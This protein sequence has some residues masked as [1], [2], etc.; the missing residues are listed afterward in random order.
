[1]KTFNK[2]LFALICLAMLGTTAWGQ[3]LTDD[4]SYT[5]GTLLTA[6][7]WV[8]HSGA[9][10]NSHFVVYPGLTYTGHA[11]SGIGGADTL[12]T[13]GE[14]VNSYYT[15][16]GT[17]ISTGTAYYSFIVKLDTAQTTGDYFAHVI[18][19]TRTTTTTFSARVWAKRDASDATKFAFG[20]SKSSTAANVAYTATTA[21]TLGTTYFV[22]VKYIFM[23]GLANDSVKLFINPVPGGTEPTPTLSN[24]ALDIATTDMT[25]ID[26][27]AIRQGTAGSMPRGKIDAFRLGTTWAS[28]TTQKNALSDIIGNVSFVYPTNIDYASNTG[29]NVTSSNP[30]V[31]GLVIRDGG[32][33]SPDG[34]AFSTTL[35]AITLSVTN[36]SVLEKVALYS[37]TTELSE[38]T[39]GSTITFSG[40]SRAAADNGTDTLNLRATYKTSVTDNTQF[41]FTVTSA[42][43]DP[44]GSTFAAGNAGGATSSTSGNDDRI[45]VTATKY[46]FSTQPPATAVVNT[47]FAAGVEA[48]DANNNRDLDDATTATLAASAGTLSSVTGLAQ[49]L[50]S[51]VYNWADLR[52]NTA[53]T[54]G[55]LSATG[56]HTTANSSTMTILS[57]E[58]TTQATGVGFSNILT[59][60]MDVTWTSGNGN[61]RIVIAKLGSAPTFT[62]SDGSTYSFD[63]DFS[64][65]TTYGDAKV[66]YKGSSNTFP[67]SGLTQNTTYYVAVFEYNNPLGTEN[68]LL[69]SPATNYQQ[70]AALVSTVSDIVAAGNETA[71]LDYASKQSATITTTSNGIM[72]W[73]FTIRD[74]GGSA[75]ADEYGTEMTSVTIDQGG[76]N[77][78]SNWSNV[79]RQAT[80]FD[81][82]TKIA[83]AT[84]IG[85]TSLAFTGLSGSN[86]TAADGG[87][88]TLDLYLSFKTTVTDNE[89]FQFQ[90]TNGNVTEAVSGS[91]LFSSF[92][93]QTSSVSG[94]ADRIEV[95]ATKLNFSTQPP[96]T[97][98]MN[99]N[100]SAGVEA[101]DANNNRDLDDATSVS[102]TAS[103]GTLSSATGL[104]QSLSSGVYNWTDLQNNTAG[105][106]VTLQATGGSLTLA[107]SSAMTI[108]SAEPT[109]QASISGFS[110]ITTSSMTANL[111]AGDGSYRIVLAKSGSAVDA[112]PVD[113]TTY[114]P[115]S[116]FG[117]G[118]QIGTGNY[119]IFAGSGT[120]APVSG[121]SAGTTYHF[122]V[123]EFNGAGGTEN[124]KT[125]G[126]IGSQITSGETYT[127]NQTGSASWAVSTNWT[128]TRTTPATNDNLQFNG[129]GTVTATSVPAQTIGRLSISN[130]TIVNLQAS[131]AVTLSIGGGTGTDFSVDGTSIL[132]FPSNSTNAISLSILTG[133]TGIVNGA[134]NF[135]VGGTNTTHRLLAA[136]A[137]GLTFANGSSFTQAGSG[138]SFGNAFGS[139]NLNSVVFASGSS[140]YFSNGSNPFAASAPNSVVIFQQG[141]TY[142]HRSSGTPS[143]SGRKYANYTQQYNGNS[144]NNFSRPVEFYSVQIDSGSLKLWNSGTTDSTIKIYG[145]LIN[146]SPTGGDLLFR[147]GTTNPIQFLSGGTQTISGTS[148]GTI[149][150]NS[151]ITVPG[152]T[153]LVLSRSINDSSG[154]MT[155]SGTLDCGTNTVA[156]GGVGGATA[157]VTVANGGVLKTTNTNAGGA[158]AATV[159]ANGG[160]T[161][162]S[163]STVE[164]NGSSHQYADLRTYENFKSNNSS[165]TTVS[166]LGNL[167]INGDLDIAAGTLDLDTYTADRATSGGTLT[168]ANGAALKIGGTNTFPANYTTHS[169]GST[170]T[171]EYYGTTQAVSNETYGSLTLSGSGTKTAAS[172]F[173][174]GGTCTVPLTITLST[175]GTITNNGTLTV[176]G[177]FQINQGGGATGNDFVYGSNT[178]LVFNNSTGSY[179]V[180]DPVR[181]W[182]ATNGP[183]NVTVQNTGGVTL[184]VDRTVTGLFQTSAQADNTSGN[185]LTVSGTVQINASGSFGNFSPTYSGTGSLVYNTGVSSNVGLEWGSGSTLGYGVPK[186]V[187]IHNSSVV[188]LP[189]TDRYVP[190]DL[191]IN[192]ATLAM[193]SGGGN[194][195]I[196]GNFTK[197]STFTPNGRT[198]IFDGTG[199]QNLSTD[200]ITFDGLTIN[201]FSG[202]VDIDHDINV[203]GTL[204][205]TSGQ[206]NT[207]AHKVTLGSSAVMAEAGNGN[208]VMGNVEAGRTLSATGNETFGDIGLEINPTGS[209][210]PG[211]TTVTRVTGTAKTGGGSNESIKRYYGVTAGTSTGLN[212]DLV[213]HYDDATAELNGKDE[214]KLMLFRSPTGNDPW[215]DV[216]LTSKNTTTNTISL[217]GVTD[218]SSWTASDS[219]N[220]LATNTSFLSDIVAVPSSEV[221]TISSL[222]NDASP[223]GSGDGEQVWQVTIRDGG[224][225]SDFDTYPTELFVMTLTQDTS[226]EVPNW[227]NAILAADLFEGGTHIDTGIVGATSI[228]FSNFSASAA[229]GGTKTLSVRISLKDP[230]PADADNQHFGFEVLNSNVT[231]G[232]ISTSSQFALF[233]A[234]LSNSS[235][236]K[237]DVVATKMAFTTEPPS[238]VN[239]NTNFSSV[240]TAQD[241]NDNTD[242]DYATNVT[243]SLNTG[244]GNLSAV[245]TL[246]HSPTNGVASWTDLQYDKGENGV[247]IKAASGSFADV[248]SSTFDVLVPTSTVS[249]VIAV[250]SSES[251]TISSLENDPSPLGSADGVQ[252]WQVTVRDGGGSAD[253]DA[254]PTILTGISFTTAASGNTVPNWS[255]AILAA[256][257]FDGSSWLASGTVGTSSIAFTGLTVTVADNNS[258]PLSLR[259]SLKNP[260][261]SVSD[262]E[263]FRL[264]VTAANVTTEDASTSSQFASFTDAVSANGQNVI[265][266]TATVLAFTTQPQTGK[267]PNQNIAPVAVTAR[268]ANGNTDLGYTGAVT[269]SSATFTI[270]STDPPTGL[271]QNASSGVASWTNLTSSTAGTGT[272]LADASSMTQGVS[273]SITIA[274]GV[275]TSVKSG[276]WSAGDTWDIGSKPTATQMAV[277]AAGH[278][279][280]LTATD[281]CAVL[282]VKN[283]GVFDYGFKLGLAGTF[284]L[285]AGA[286]AKVSA[287][288]P[289]P[290][291]GTTPYAF[292]LAST[293]EFY[294]GATG[295]TYS[296][297]QTS[298]T[299]GN[300]NWNATGNATPAVGTI[301]QGNLVKRGAGELR[302]GTGS[303]PSGLSRTIVVHGNVNI[304]AGVLVSNNGTSPITGAIDIDGDLT[305]DSVGSVRG[306][307]WTGDGTI[308]VGGNF[309]NSGSG[310]MVNMKPA[311]SGA[312]GN[313]T[314]YFKGTNTSTFTPGS[315][316]S[317]RTFIVPI[318]KIVNVTTNGFGVQRSIQDSGALYLGTNVVKDVGNFLLAAGATL[319]IGSPDG[320]TT[321]GA[322]G[323]I[324]V[325]GTRTFSS[326]ANYVYNGSTTQVTG[327]GLPSVVNNLT[328]NNT[329]GVA[330]TPDVPPPPP[331]LL[332]KKVVA[333][334]TLTVNGTLTLAGGNLYTGAYIV[335]VGLTGTVSR[336]SGQ[337]VG[338]M[339]KYFATDVTTQIFEIGDSTYYTPVDVSFAGVTGGGSLRV[340][341][342]REEH[343]QIATSGLDA[344]KSI[345]RYY[346]LS[347]NGITF[348]TYNATF[349]FVTGDVD[350]G[351]SPLNFIAKRYNGVNWNTMTMGT[352][353]LTST[354]VTGVTSF[355]DFAIG[356]PT[357]ITYQLTVNATTGGTI[358]VPSSSPVTVDHGVAT[359]ITASANPGYHFVNW[360][361]PVGTASITDANAISTTATLTSGDATVQA[362]FAVT[363]YQLTVNATTGG[364]ITAPATSPVTVNH[365]VATTITATATSGYA[366]T[367]WTVP[368]G[369]AAIANSSV[370]STTATLTGGDATVLA[371]FIEDPAYQVMYRSFMP[372]SIALD[373]DNKGKIN[374]YVLRRPD[375]IEFEFFVV[376]DSPNVNDLHL[377]FSVAIDT[378]QFPFRTIP[379]ALTMNNPD[380][381]MKKWDLTF[382]PALDAGDTVWVNGYG[383]KKTLQKVSKYYWTRNTVLVGEK[384]KNP[385]FTVNLPRLPMPNRVNALYETMLNK[386][387]AYGPNGFV[388]G[389]NRKLTV[390]DSGKYYGWLQTAKYGDLLKTLYYKK[391]GMLNTGT[392]RGFDHLTGK[393]AD[394]VKKKTSLPPNKF[395]N[396]LLAELIA[397]KVNITA[398]AM[399]IT[400]NGFGELV[401][402][403]PPYGVYPT[404]FE[405]ASLIEIAAA[406]DA[407]MMGQYDATAGMKLFAPPE[408]F[409]TLD[410]VVRLINGAFEGAVDTSEF[411][412]ALHFTGTKQLVDVPFLVPN[413]YAIPAVITPIASTEPEV[414]LAYSLY[415]NYPNPFNP[416]TTISFDLPEDA[417][418]TLK[419]YNMLGQEV[420]TLFDRE[421]LYNGTQE[422]E[423]S[424][425]G[426]A[427]GVY[428]YR[429]VAEGLDEDGA[430]TSTYQTVK[431]M[432]LLK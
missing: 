103:A 424:A 300:V 239:I 154:T 301:V 173:T 323:N 188:T 171:V 227:S 183:E 23:T 430:T 224:A 354:Q 318:G 161:L 192:N 116:T 38:V 297:T 339:L 398:S 158:L 147:A 136:D 199:T 341:T 79:I 139:T 289:I 271:T 149:R 223:L 364:T 186:D 405:G 214:N 181:F 329:E 82:S 273:N 242:A 26:G 150:L 385:I 1:M 378:S 159:T 151:N 425:D 276:N 141:S 209:P 218:L 409:A 137:S 255:N 360:T 178:T 228:T 431:K 114:S 391:T 351:A 52:N 322:T 396:K 157:S 46:N 95:S 64:I 382:S 380:G 120:S 6:N 225:A 420:A 277:I 33:S 44:T 194:L 284:T 169:V 200:G 8:A 105:T 230:L 259:I 97:T 213:F 268:D 27:V 252:A 280:T 374:K 179:G 72:V 13:S 217:N 54:G 342:V 5:A 308:K 313:F 62:P 198:V 247:D 400:P 207:G 168:L 260:L 3:L 327:V 118:D 290:G 407:M 422:I 257:L 56:T 285:E 352:R 130:S 49:P 67:L 131:A 315:N 287:Y 156:G 303:L 176:N 69:T 241:A 190:G 132:N 316:D 18:T 142:Y 406:G 94:D 37:G 204:T 12:R 324:Q 30:E 345:N 307:N 288:Q 124:Y 310:Q 175:G 286:T 34:D 21:Y 9:G 371:N 45:E 146:N 361:N 256:D 379:S 414:P 389:V 283:G 39:A 61:N 106:G 76:S 304:K 347:N 109:S 312:T 100:V 108:Y 134:I 265:D 362:N 75:D 177:I 302:C 326:E 14:D 10:T 418:V 57:A 162:N 216:G 412:A 402:N 404:D 221:S 279:V 263:A 155:V 282:T 359:T 126:G 22:T 35:T 211:A 248:I 269:L 275:I 369:S 334:A 266:V 42:T 383:N 98:F 243:L 36:S 41:S 330:L 206:L 102:L 388:I 191:T 336:T 244:T 237:I 231:A 294:S 335:G 99:T 197:S 208:I 15:A 321:S 219:A 249:D 281:T 413:P 165:P 370:L 104:T 70:T 245:S 205:V 25:F 58:P 55:S 264:K 101:L 296:L 174:L 262:G 140:F 203:N 397:L 85:S 292:D 112:N 392:A 236:N 235:S 346:T 373:K 311:T 240:V 83:D 278:T 189:T 368:V 152:G 127:W 17:G 357:V 11:G 320:I 2:I 337:I 375:K 195:Y 50:S 163:G 394:L 166:L 306:V 319:G 254:L 93:A 123:F 89:Q 164:L 91:S 270:A 376:V 144:T 135:N 314:I 365:G 80:L 71:N 66:V 298:I 180:D 121:L 350:P 419:I 363:T 429:I 250:G 387:A 63:N 172:G 210:Y 408:E 28:V 333:D 328:I 293:Y 403:P 416:T 119:V 153:T 349:N 226:N 148:S 68:Y 399:G 358:T 145:D 401:Y 381:K 233:T 411:G 367:G 309:V 90:I 372:E 87:S 332:T 356:E 201:K 390:P 88:K 331:P 115:S 305:I 410:S 353:S 59:T 196:A 193:N 182:P 428:F 432:M 24:S 251:A 47:N 295:F 258:K 426:F 16:S 19:G 423:F 122:A 110:S 84:T 272:V 73:S 129:G 215:T 4:F 167:T 51:G 234:P 232:N 117:S 125:P 7:G 261:P 92:S 343:Y 395:D 317:C 43:A 384:M 415:Q 355:S 253:I 170:S 274:S 220:P 78:I 32:A 128:P 427:S 74:G 96:A 222:M 421:E 138:G 325:A 299:F 65:A 29:T 160:L 113:G 187:L 40:L 20:I 340:S 86:V 212:L 348:T 238:T 229:D 377:E 366:F 60:S 53:G 338:N 31:F 267:L 184:N 202:A 291:G 344:T 111:S 81:G 143:F 77:G 393:T 386:A 133:A 246:T 185:D 107:N 48:L 417:F